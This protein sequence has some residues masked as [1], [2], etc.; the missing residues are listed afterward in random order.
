ML[1]KRPI[2]AHPVYILVEWHHLDSKKHF[3]V[4]M[5]GHL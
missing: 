1:L 2:R 4:F 3:H 5:M